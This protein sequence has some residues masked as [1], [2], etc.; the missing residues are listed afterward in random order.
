[1]IESGK[2]KDANINL[3]NKLTYNLFILFINSLILSI[4]KYKLL[5]VY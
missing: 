1:M 2:N 4:I 5:L 3:E